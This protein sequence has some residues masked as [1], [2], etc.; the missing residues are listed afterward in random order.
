MIL[1]GKRILFISSKFFNYEEE[2]KNEIETM[3][4]IVD[5][6][7]E[8]PANTTFT[9]ALIRLNLKK[10]I[11]FKINR[12]YKNII[13]KIKNIKYDY[14]FLIAPETITV[15]IFLELKK[16]QKNA[17]FIL[18]MW[19]SFNNKKNCFN[20]INYFDS[21]FT[22]DKNDLNI[23]KNIKF[24]PLFYIRDYENIA[25]KKN[26][27][28]DLCF[29]GTVHSDRY[30]ILKKIEKQAN[31]NGLKCYFYFYFPSKL[32]FWF[33]KIFDKDFR[34]AKYKEFYFK[35]LLK[36]EVLQIIEKSRAVIDIEHPKQTG[37]TMRTIEVFGAKRKL[38]TTNSC[39][40]DYDLYNKNNITI[41]DRKNPTLSIDIIKND[42]FE[43]EKNMYE[44]Y[45]LQNW[46]KEIFLN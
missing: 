13:E 8:R 24:R 34:C 5:Y 23:N 16:Q 43:L 11:Y 20:L 36:Q 1:K 29:I 22:F 32:Y 25:N 2:I 10:I 28:Y 46:I 33:R 41:I 6:F 19:D 40:K 31:D 39:I 21:I 4:G 38:I 37:L 30:K 45:S 44:K 12:Y 9:K 14:V 3:G 35:P 15:N 26:Y 18:Y 7:D 42:Y 27:K 17:K